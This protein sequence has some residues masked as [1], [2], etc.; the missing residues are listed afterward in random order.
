MKEN[1][2]N[3]K[4]PLTA[5][6]LQ[7]WVSA[8]AWME[9]IADKFSDSAKQAEDQARHSAETTLKYYAANEMQRDARAWQQCANDLRWQIKMKKA[10]MGI[11][12]EKH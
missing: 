6:D 9:Q 2:H 4:K 5:V 11:D 12:E 7:R 10:E 1:A 8:F 3:E